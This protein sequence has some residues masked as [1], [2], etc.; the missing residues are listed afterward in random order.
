MCTTARAN[1]VI[2]GLALL[3]LAVSVGGYLSADVYAAY[4]VVFHVLLPLAVLAINVAVVREVRRASVNAATSLGVH[5]HHQSNSAVPTI[6]LV[7]ASLVYV[8][9]RGT[10]SVL[11]LGVM[12]LLDGVRS[13]PRGQLIAD[14]LSKLVFAYNFYVYVITGEQFR[15]ELR[16]LFCRSFSSSSSASPTPAAAVTVAAANCNDAID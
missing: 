5:H 10:A 7:S 3:A 2:V 11:T 16:A 9:L 4:L 8:L 12:N 1:Q 14:A 13:M 6:M 15:S